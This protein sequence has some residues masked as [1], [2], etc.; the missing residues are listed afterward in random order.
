MVAEIQNLIR[1][2]RE[3]QR[4]DADVEDV[5]HAPAVVMARLRSLH[6]EATDSSE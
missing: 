3:R 1:A 4:L 2:E 6:N 5:Q